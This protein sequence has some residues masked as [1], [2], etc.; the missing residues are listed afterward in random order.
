MKSILFVVLS[1]LFGANVI[2]Q[3]QIGFPS[4]QQ[5]HYEIDTIFEH[6]GPLLPTGN[7]FI[8]I[9][10]ELN[11]NFITGLQFKMVV[12]S[13]SLGGAA[14]VNKGDTLLIPAAFQLFTGSIGF[15]VIIEGTPE[16]AGESYFCDLVYFL[17][18]GLDYEMVIGLASYDSCFVENIEGIDNFQ[19]EENFKIFPNPTSKLLTINASDQIVGSKFMICD[20]LGRQVLSGILT[21][22]STTIDIYHLESGVYF[23][24]IE[25]QDKKTIKLIKK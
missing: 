11:T 3:I 21:N 24:Q 12:D 2:A 14:S 6:Y 19:Y 7:G 1:M 23:F 18:L 4:Y 13:I 22:K 10:P 20:K 15:H 25:Q 17:M 8:G 16:T 9:D 5:G